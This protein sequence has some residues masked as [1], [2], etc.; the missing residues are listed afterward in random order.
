MVKQNTK[1]GRLSNCEFFTQHN[2]KKQEYLQMAKQNRKE[3]TLSKCA[4][5][6]QQEYFKMVKQNRKGR[7]AFKIHIFYTT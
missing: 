7:Q 6:T 5:F 2:F 3:D 4:Y 1:S